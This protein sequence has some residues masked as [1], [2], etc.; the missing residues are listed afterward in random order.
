MREILNFASNNKC[1]FYSS[2]P[3]WDTSNNL[4]W[5]KNISYSNKS[6]KNKVFNSWKKNFIYFL[7]GFNEFNILSNKINN[8]II[9]DIE[10]SL[11]SMVNFLDS[12]LY[13]S[14]PTCPE[15]PNSR[16]FIFLKIHI[17]YLYWTIWGLEKAT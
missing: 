7:T 2:S 6:S 3:S 13:T 5:Y 9:N 15:A 17:L 1:V 10:K 16:I 8:S 14:D 4:N 11:F 12:N